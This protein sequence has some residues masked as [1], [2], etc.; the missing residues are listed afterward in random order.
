MALRLGNTTQKGRV[1]VGQLSL[2][3]IIARGASSRCH[4]AFAIKI[5]ELIKVE[6]CSPKQLT[7]MCKQVKMIGQPLCDRP[8][9]LI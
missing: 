4:I 5:I 8:Y 3:I 2:N 9:F 7:L 1:H 6:S